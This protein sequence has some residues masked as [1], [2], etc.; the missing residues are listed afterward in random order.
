[1][2]VIKIDLAKKVKKMKVMH[3]TGQPPL[4][5]RQNFSGNM[6]YLSDIGVPY[7]RLHDTG[8]VYGAN[9]YVDIPNIFRDFDADVNDPA[10]YDF[11]FTDKL[12]TA[13][14][15]AGIEPY[16]RLGVTIETLSCIKAY[17]I[18]PPKDFEKWAQICE[19][20]IAHYT[21]GWADGFNYKITYW[22]IWNEPD[23]GF[24]ADYPDGSPYVSQMWI[25]TKEEYYRLYEVAS[26]HLK[27][28]FP[29]IKIGGYSSCGFSA[30]L[31]DEEE[32]ALHPEYAYHLEFFHGFWKYVKEH[33][34]PID[35]F[36]WHT[37]S[38]VNKVGKYDEYLH[39][40][41]EEYGY[42]HIE[43]H[44]TEW[45]PAVYSRGT[46]VHSAEIAAIMAVMQ[47]GYTDMLMLYDAHMR[48]GDYQ[49][50][51]DPRTY[52]PVHA[53]YALA[54]FNVLY[55]L[56]TQV[57]LECED[58]GI[59]AIAASNGERSAILI[60][61]LSGATRKLEFEGVDLTG[62]RWHLIDDSRLLSWS[63]ALDK[64]ENNSVVLIEF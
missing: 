56:G 33:D 10:S 58:K 44:L 60:S 53:Y 41:L 9:R 12:I 3:A 15:E 59:Y 64:I 34:C 26:K 7:S 57:S 47:N 55:K 49:A 4:G 30:I 40:T 31:N 32:L 48:G 16:Y 50:L 63:P 20:I 29:N 35:F 17:R 28:R 61:N 5:G 2:S 36:S 23:D 39:K 18:Y 27:K 54:A 42:G 45:N 11:A 25:G 62:A 46:A 8:G 21:E 52:K 14:V 6:H 24:R 22:E 38:R 37:Y 19:H 1:M 43:K 51:F 13:L